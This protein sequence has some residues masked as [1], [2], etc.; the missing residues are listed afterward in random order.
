MAVD[1][2]DPKAVNAPLTGSMITELSALAK[3]AAPPS[4]EELTLQPEQITRFAPYAAH[5]DWSVHTGTLSEAELL[6]LIRLFTLG[7]RQYAT[8]AAGAK[9]PVAAMV[10]E[11]KSRD[12]LPADLNSWI[13]QHTKNRF[14]PYGD[15]IQRL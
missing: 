14:L 7:E 9:S 15:L 5:N 6:S 10:S 12:A 1:S 11:L 2:F 4:C 8:W 13:K 3:A